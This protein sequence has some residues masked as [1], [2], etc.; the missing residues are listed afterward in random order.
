VIDP[1][2]RY[3]MIRKQNGQT[4]VLSFFGVHPTCLGSRSMLLSR[5]YPGVLVDA[6][7]KL[8]EVDFAAFGAGAV[9]SQRPAGG[10]AAEDRMH[11]LGAG[12]AVRLADSLHNTGTAPTATLDY[13]RFPLLL[14]SPQLR[15]T[16]SLRV[17]PRIFDWMIGEND[18]AIDALLL[19]DIVLIGLPCD[20]S[21][22]LVADL[23]SDAARAGKALILANFNGGYIG[24]VSPDHYDGLDTYETRDM[25]WYGPGSGSYLQAI[26]RKIVDASA[27]Q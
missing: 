25:N 8:E 6:L 3:V 26:V 22:E 19:G 12:L 20:F 10:S 2:L 1:W 21:A 16:D 17:A 24:Y 15:I 27:R 14:R 18:P 13:D 5:D 23:E 4:A 9:G 11:L 7:E